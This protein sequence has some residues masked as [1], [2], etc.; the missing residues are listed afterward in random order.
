MAAVAV[1]PVVVRLD[2]GEPRTAV[3]QLRRDLEH[4]RDARELP[5]LPASVALDLVPA[6]RGVVAA[7]RL[8]RRGAGM[9]P[10]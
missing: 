10:A 2:R 6:V 8:V 3:S 5:G 7:R 9:T 4:V 1:E